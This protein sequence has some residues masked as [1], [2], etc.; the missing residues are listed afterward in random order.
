MRE[1]L[2]NLWIVVLE[3][4]IWEYADVHRT[5]CYFFQH[6]YPGCRD[7]SEEGG[8]C[9]CSLGNPVLDT[10]WPATVTDSSNVLGIFYGR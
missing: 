6:S 5:F 2:A 7:V 4:H 10:Q 3:P 1:R 8:M 9:W